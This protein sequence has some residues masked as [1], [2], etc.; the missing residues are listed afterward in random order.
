M[1]LQKYISTE[2]LITMSTPSASSETA[3]IPSQLTPALKIP[4]R[5]RP[6][7]SAPVLKEPKLKLSGSRP[8]YDVHNF[9]K[10]QLKTE[11]GLFLYCGNGFSPT[12]DQLLQ[13]LYDCF[14]VGDELMIM[15]GIQENWG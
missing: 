3:S 8:V 15:Y 10:T 14:R 5:L 11:N 1:K 6:V 2:H 12:P 13:D 7:G 9:L 4:I